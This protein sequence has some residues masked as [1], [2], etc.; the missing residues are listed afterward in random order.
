M[1]GDVSFHSTPT[2]GRVD[3]LASAG[4]LLCFLQ[5]FAGRRVPTFDRS[6]ELAAGSRNTVGV[7][8][9]GIAPLYVVHRVS[10]GTLGAQPV[11]ISI[12]DSDG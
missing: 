2:L 10:N 8:Q 4:G 9:F 3:W 1:D 6:S 11:S 12:L 7:G 5:R